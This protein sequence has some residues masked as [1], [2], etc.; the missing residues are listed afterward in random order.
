ELLGL[1]LVARA[2]KGFQGGLEP[3][4]TSGKRTAGDD[5]LR[6][7]GPDRGALTRS[8]TN[9]AKGRRVEP[10]SGATGRVCGRQRKFAARQ[11]LVAARVRGNRIVPIAA[12]KNARAAIR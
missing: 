2:E 6:P 7:V 3:T 5:R 4:R 11:V 1:T 10:L 9:H 12:T 8:T